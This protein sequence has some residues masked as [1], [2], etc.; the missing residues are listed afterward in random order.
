[1]KAISQIL[2][3][4]S[5][6]FL[7]VALLIL[8]AVLHSGTTIKGGLYADDYIHAAFFQGSTVLEEKGLLDGVAVGEF[9]PLLSQQFNFFDPRSENYQALKDSGILPW[10][11]SDQALLHFFRPLATASHYLDYKLWPN[12]SHVMHF[13]N[14]LWYLVGLLAIYYLLQSVGLARP[15]IFVSLL[16][17]ILDNSVYQVVTWIAARSMLMLIAF[18]FFAVAAYHKSMHSRPWYIV[19][20]VAL[21]LALLSAEG[22]IAI[23]AYLGAYLLTLDTRSWLK[24]IVH[25]LPFVMIVVIWRLYYQAQGFGAFGVDFY[26]DP[27]REP[28][29]FLQA[30]LYR[31]PGN[32]FELFTS[33]DIASGQIRADIRQGYAVF[34]LAL[35]GLLVWLLWPQ[36]KADKKLQFFALG[37]LF[38]LV[39]GLSIALAPR[40]MVLPY[41][42]FA[43]VLAYIL[44]A[45]RQQLLQGA[46]KVFAKIIN[47]YTILV[48]GLIAFLL[49]IF[50]LYNTADFGGEKVLERGN[51]ALGVD[52]FAGKHLVIINSERPFWLSFVAHELAS[53]GEALPQ[54]V[55]VLATNFYPIT[56]ERSGENSLK[57]IAAPAFQYDPEMINTAEEKAHGHYAYLTQ[58]LLG[59]F[60][61]KRE[62]WQRDEQYAL[63][64]MIITVDA[65]YQGK[66]SELTVVFNKP[67]ETYRFAYWSQAD[68][69]YRHFSLPV[70]GEE[71]ELDG[72]F[73]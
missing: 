6:R 62:P 18:G 34:G 52:D 13:I 61:S 14:L 44:H 12:N 19:S 46:R 59:L 11:T 20:L 45:A 26:I 66:P 64:E 63:P 71:A 3:N 37:S 25:I 42:G 70:V 5:N 23:C 41:V 21:T 32:F 8:A 60:R 73:H 24:R 67:L 57:L 28:I 10:W 9:W 35:A 22:A 39:P 1:M 36:L 17:L 48:N 15:I 65:L 72:M 50:M 43:V 38:A 56:V 27:G 30:A 51:V 16:L 69:A 7:L 2:H 58:Q 55:R 4:T 33:I 40:V 29:S 54:S 31:L 49:C 68:K 47:G 53:K